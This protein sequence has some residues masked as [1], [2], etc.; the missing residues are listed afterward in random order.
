MLSFTLLSNQYVLLKRRLLL[1]APGCNDITGQREE[2]GDLDGI[3]SGSAN[4]ELGFRRILAAQVGFKGHVGEV[5]KPLCVL[6]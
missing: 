2:L 5:K 1:F 3:R 6:C 4:G